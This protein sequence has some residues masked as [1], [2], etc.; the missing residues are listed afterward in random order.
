MTT[1]DPLSKLFAF[2]N[3]E[4][5]YC[6]LKG[7][8]IQSLLTDER[9]VDT[10]VESLDVPRKAR[11]LKGLSLEEKLAAIRAHAAHVTTLEISDLRGLSF[12]EAIVVAIWRSRLSNRRVLKDLFH[13]RSRENELLEPVAIWLRSQG[14][15]ASDEVSIGKKRADV[16][17]H[18]APSFGGLVSRKIIAVELKNDV[19]EFERAMD[20]M[21]TYRQYAHEVY[22]ACPP[23]M[24]MQYLE[25]HALARGVNAWNTRILDEK[26]SGVGLGL[27]LVERDGVSVHLAAR[28]A[29]LSPPNIAELVRTLEAR[30]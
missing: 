24:A 21:S 27:L 15:D 7:K 16:V 19:K 9:I 20:Q 8:A 14:F 28:G 6:Y 12:E 23:A 2:L 18:R 10:V 26:L 1:M 13:A 25:E 17:G 30:R 11:S 29:D 3:P 5:R 22:L 4:R